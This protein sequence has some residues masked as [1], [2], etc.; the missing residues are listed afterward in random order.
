MDEWYSRRDTSCGSDNGLTCNPQ[1]KACLFDI[2]SDPCEMRNIADLLGNGGYIEQI[3]QMISRF[4]KTVK[5][6]ASPE[7]DPRGNPANFG[8]VWEPWVDSV[9]MAA[10]TTSHLLHII[11][12]T[13]VTTL[14]YVTR[15]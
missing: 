1:S 7:A 11:I 6:G 10:V 2:R 3:K 14:N 15:S 12:P 9:N 13:I 5:Y 4:N 8:G